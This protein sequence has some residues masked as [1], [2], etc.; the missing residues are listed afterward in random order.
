[1]LNFPGTLQMLGCIPRTP[2][3]DL[4]ATA[5]PR[6]SGSLNPVE[7]KGVG[8]DQ[9]EEVRNLRVSHTPYSQPLAQYLTFRQAQLTH[10]ESQAKIKPENGNNLSGVKREC[11]DRT[12]TGPRKKSR[13]STSIEI[14][15]L[16]AD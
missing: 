12:S 6:R 10:V 8:A 15:D 9:D 16:T 13:G 4:E 2:F 3:P 14:V 5:Q 7:S 11:D 1:M